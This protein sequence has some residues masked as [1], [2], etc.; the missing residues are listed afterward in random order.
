MIVGLRGHY[1]HFDELPVEVAA[2]FMVDVQRI[3]GILRKGLGAHRVNVAILGNQEP[4]VHA[5]VI[6]RYS[7]REP[8]PK[9]SPWQDP[10][11]REVLEAVEREDIIQRICWWL[12]H[13]SSTYDR[14]D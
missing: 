1:D 13:P 11:T 8:L 7:V 4:H 3:S 9:K 5:H 12:D 2:A 10:R 6:P 14:R